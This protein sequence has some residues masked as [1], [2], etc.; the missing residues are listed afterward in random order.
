MKKSFYGYALTLVMAFGI[1]SCGKS[2]GGGGG[3]ATTS[4]ITSG[5]I[6]QS[7][8][9]TVTAFNNW[10]AA[11]ETIG[12][13]GCGN[14]SLTRTTQSVSSNGSNCSQNTL[15]GFI[16][17]TWCSNSSNSGSSSGTGT[18]STV[19]VSCSST[20]KSSSA[21]LAAIAG[22]SYGT[23]V[24]AASQNGTNGSPAYVLVFQASDGAITTHIVD[25]Y[26]P[27]AFQPLQTTSSSSSSTSF[28]SKILKI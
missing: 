17:Y 20:S 10:Y 25:T 2:G 24:H 9:E 5:N 23:L 19:A 18:T 13:P 16:N 14:Y 8:T 3:G 11:A 27:A 15:F 26:Y 6:S 22:G 7:A 12:Y 21:A 28:V 1:A 4:L